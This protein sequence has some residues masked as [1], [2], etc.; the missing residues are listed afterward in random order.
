[1]IR[2]H[3]TTKYSTRLITIIT[4]M[5]ILQFL[6]VA[7]YTVPSVEHNPHQ[8]TIFYPSILTMNMYLHLYISLAIILLA[9][10]ADN[11]YWLEP[12][13]SASH[14]GGG[15]EGGAPSNKGGWLPPLHPLCYQ[16]HIQDQTLY[17]Y[18]KPT[19]ETNN[20]R[21]IGHATVHSN[22]VFSMATTTNMLL[23]C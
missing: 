20:P 14:M 1:M 22:Q 21:G 15:G 11:S 6:I 3:M 19:Q 2:N 8:E 5:T 7:T 10:A 13:I 23:L 9:T 4:Y 16:I 18:E 12:Q 17:T